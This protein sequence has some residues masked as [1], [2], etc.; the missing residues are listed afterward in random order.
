[1]GALVRVGNARFPVVSFGRLS[2]NRLIHALPHQ[3]SAHNDGSIEVLTGKTPRVPDL[4]SQAHSE[5]PDFGMVAGRLRGPRTD[6][7]PRYIGVQRSPFMTNPAYL[8]VAH[9][10]FDT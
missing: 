2:H 5:H 9:R 7:L 4:T 6:G 1:M 10:A 8:G 3:M